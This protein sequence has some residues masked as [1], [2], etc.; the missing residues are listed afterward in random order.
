[1]PP[2]YRRSPTPGWSA[3]TA[4][5]RPTWMSFVSNG[6]SALATARPW[7]DTT[8]ALGVDVGCPSPPRLRLEDAIDASYLEPSQS[9]T[10]AIRQQGALP[11]PSTGTP[12][13][14]TL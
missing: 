11:R 13:Q 5:P 4:P 9:A 14:H 10:T 7:R 1:M 3:A 8:E 2:S 12:A 6:S